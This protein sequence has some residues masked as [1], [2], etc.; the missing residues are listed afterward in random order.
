MNE[1]CGLPRDKILSKSAV[2]A[3]RKHKKRKV[4][5][6]T[7]EFKRRRLQL[8][9]T[10]EDERQHKEL[11]EGPSY[12]PGLFLPTAI[13]NQNTLVIPPKLVPTQLE[14]ISIDEDSM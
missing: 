12:E 14:K 5:A 9:A 13:D 2:K 8:K 7:V 6:A 10:A 3:S 11:R 1:F 4:T